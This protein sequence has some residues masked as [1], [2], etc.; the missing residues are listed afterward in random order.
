MPRESIRSRTFTGGRCLLPFGSSRREPIS[1]PAQI[2]PSSR[3]V[4]GLEHKISVQVITHY[5][6]ERQCLW[7]AASFAPKFPA[8]FAQRFCGTSCSA[9]WR[10][11]QPGHLAKVHNPEVAE[12]RG[13]AISAWY[14]SG[15]PRADA[16]R[17]RIANLNPMARPEVR[18]KVS[19]RLREMNHRPSVRGGNGTGMTVPQSILLGFLGE[20]WIPEF[21]L[22][23]GRRTPGFPTCYKL[24]LANVGR[25][26]AI[27][28]DGN[29]H[30]ARKDQDRKK[31]DK[32]ASLG[33]TVLRFWNRDI[34]T[35]NDS[36]RPTDGSI[37]MTLAAHGI[38]PTP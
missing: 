14:K 15:D 1:F 9:K 21:A 25:R 6:Q 2:I 32:L 24:D 33:W 11:R 38:L 7:C 27:E 26:I 28:V 17:D 10:M 22:S 4:D 36:G 35:W 12:R 18:E 5:A 8:G 19:R 20:G 34:L 31:E 13:R 37:S 23:L 29:T 3:S 16:A 30:H